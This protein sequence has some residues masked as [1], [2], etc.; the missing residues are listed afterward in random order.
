MCQTRLR[1]VQILSIS[2]KGLERGLNADDDDAAADDVVV[3]DDGDDEL[4]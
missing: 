4:V 2:K 1:H 3:D